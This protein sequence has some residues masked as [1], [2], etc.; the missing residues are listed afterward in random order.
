MQCVVQLNYTNRECSRFNLFVEIVD[1]GN[2]TSVCA[3][4]TNAL[5]KSGT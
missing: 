3:G 2:G 1:E 5:C 4:C